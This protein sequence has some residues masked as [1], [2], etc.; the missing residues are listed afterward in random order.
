MVRSSLVKPGANWMKL[1]SSAKWR[2]VKADPRL[3]SRQEFSGKV[4]FNLVQIS[5]DWT[6]KGIKKWNMGMGVR[7]RLREEHG[8]GS[9]DKNMA[10]CMW[11]DC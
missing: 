2:M 7:T 4:C 10:F 9:E 3:S 8:N 6:L 11:E 5:S 1:T